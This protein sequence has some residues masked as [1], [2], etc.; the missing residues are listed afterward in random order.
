MPPQDAWKFADRLDY[1]FTVLDVWENSEGV[2]EW[3]RVS[4]IATASTVLLAVQMCY[5][6][7][8]KADVITE[9]G[10]QPADVRTFAVH[11]RYD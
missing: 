6:G 8:A 11:L 1:V 7:L 3:L 4:S 10:Q 9:T 2:V 5:A